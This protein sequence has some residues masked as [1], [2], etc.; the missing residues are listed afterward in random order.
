M[1]QR[2][3]LGSLAEGR[4]FGVALSTCAHMCGCARVWGLHGSAGRESTV[5]ISHGTAR[6]PGR[7]PP[8]P[9]SDSSVEKEAVGGSAPPRLPPA[10][11]GR[12]PEAPG[13]LGSCGFR[14]SASSSSCPLF[15]R[16]VGRP[17]TC[18]ETQTA[19]CVHRSPPP[20]L[21]RGSQL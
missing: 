19:H 21:L 5:P 8:P 7:V 18:A 14:G 2:F 13:L 12:V 11:S 3:A 9:A 16:Q 6:S 15:G 10:K 20:L 1:T 17:H 4:G